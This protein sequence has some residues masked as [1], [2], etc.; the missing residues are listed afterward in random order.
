MTDPS[1]DATRGLDP[2]DAKL[3]TLARGARARIQ[4]ACGAA[5]RDD[6]GRTYAA[7][8]APLPR[9]PIAALH[10]AVAQAAVSGAR[11]L[12]MAVVVCAD[13]ATPPDVSIA[14]DLG[15]GVPVLVCAPDG[16]VVARLTAG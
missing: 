11:S 3:V 6:T 10:L 8:D 1:A 15:G 13:P 5:V 4:A 12:E 16:S 7:A 14:A 9:G 2:E